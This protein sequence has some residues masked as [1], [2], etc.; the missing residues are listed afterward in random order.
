[1]REWLREDDNEK[2][3]KEEDRV[4]Y[5]EKLNDWEDWLYEDGSN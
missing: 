3:V 1:M 5:I 4:A 2:F